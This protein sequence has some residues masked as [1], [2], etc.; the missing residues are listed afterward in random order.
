MPAPGLPSDQIAELERRVAIVSRRI[1]ELEAER[2]RGGNLEER[3]AALEEAHATTAKT[4]Q[5]TI[6]ALPEKT[7]AK[8]Q[9][10]T[11]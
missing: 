4:L 9:D 5:S 2:G 6:D 1:E 3:V 7:A 10:Q 8:I 11:D